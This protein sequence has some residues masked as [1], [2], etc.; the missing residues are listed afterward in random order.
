MRTKRTLARRRELKR[1]LLVENLECRRLLAAT[2][3]ASISGRVYDDFSN[4]G[5]TPGEEIA[6]ATLSL[7]RDNGDSSFQIASDSLIQTTASS[8]SGLYEFSRLTA[9]DYFVIQPAQSVGG[10]TL[11]EKISSLLTVSANAVEGQIVETIDNF[12]LTQQ[13]V[14]DNTNDGVP[15]TNAV[16][17]P[18]AIGGERDL[19]VNLTS[20]NGELSLSVDEPAAEP[21]ALR[22]PFY[23]GRSS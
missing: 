11:V 20:S 17:A 19:F 10:T 18:E 4:D 15:V 12:D 6:G 23:G 3:L 8:S 14:L 9:G 1:R 21:A 16:A 13:S 7:Y 22:Q 2:D 5:Y